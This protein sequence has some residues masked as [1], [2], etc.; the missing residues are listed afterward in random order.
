MDGGIVPG[1]RVMADPAVPRIGETLRAHFGP[2]LVKL[3]LYG[4]RARGEARPDSDYDV[5]AFVRG[6]VDRFAEAR[7]L[8]DVQLGIWEQTGAEVDVRVFPEGAWAERTPFMMTVREDG[9]A[10]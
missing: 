2:R 4:S 9:V 6:P 7:A 3:V 5:A 1:L 8:G 10:L